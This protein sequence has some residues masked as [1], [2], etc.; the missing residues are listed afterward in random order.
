LTDSITEIIAGAR[1]EQR[2]YL[3]EHECKAIL[4]SIGVPTTGCLVAKS[5]DEA[6]SMSEAIGYPVVLK[7][8][9]PEIIH[10]S[11]AG[12]VK[13][14]VGRGEVGWGYNELVA[15]FKD[16]NVIGVSVQ[17]MAQPGLEVIVGATTDAAFG[18]VLMFGLGGIF[19]EVLKDVS[20]T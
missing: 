4:R 2:G 7:I 15:R 13:L 1:R 20:L 12:G 19:V 5:E 3:L 10:K 17:E 9:S 14:N 8:L 18:P 11:D 16:H 6:V